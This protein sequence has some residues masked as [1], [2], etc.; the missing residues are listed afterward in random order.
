VHEPSMFYWPWEL[1][2]VI[3]EA[4]IMIFGYDA[5]IRVLAANNLMGIRDHARNLLA[6]LRNERAKF[7][8]CDIGLL[9]IVSTR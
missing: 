5:N 8:V 3:N 2:N 6:R 9:T 4:R 1:R 7:P